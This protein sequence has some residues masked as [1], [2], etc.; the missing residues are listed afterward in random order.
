MDVNML[1]R[2]KGDPNYQSLVKE[3]S[4]FGWTLAILMLVLYYGYLTLVAFDPAVIGVKI[5]GMITVGLL[6]GAGLI[7]IS[8]VLTG[9][10]VLRANTRYDALTRAIVAKAT[11][12]A[13]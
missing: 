3:R 12:A 2:V 6:L 11:G 10:Y 9:I 8:V 4:G 13:R 1:A 5:G 7:L